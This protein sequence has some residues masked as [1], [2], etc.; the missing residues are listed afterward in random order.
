MLDEVYH[1]SAKDEEVW[2]YNLRACC[3]HR[4]DVRGITDCSYRSDEVGI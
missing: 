4:N 1:E 3:V 2:M